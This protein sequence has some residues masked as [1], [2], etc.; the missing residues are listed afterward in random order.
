[1]RSN[2]ED[3]LIQS[4]ISSCEAWA[5]GY[6][7]RVFQRNDYE[8]IASKWC[9]VRLENS[10]NFEDVVVMVH[11][12][13]SYD[14]ILASE[15]TLEEDGFDAFIKFIDSEPALLDRSDA[16]KITY[17]SGYESADAPDNVKLGILKAISYHYD[18]RDIENKRFSNTAELLLMPY[19]VF[20]I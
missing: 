14:T 11:N 17:T 12:G 7:K 19:R 9:E 13:T 8:L 1:M 3:I 20:R 18:N 10:P 4:L 2:S 15:Y 16:I 6:C 5:N